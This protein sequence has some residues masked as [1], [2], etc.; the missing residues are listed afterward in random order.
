MLALPFSIL[1]GRSTTRRQASPTEGP[2]SA[3]SA[4]AR[5]RS[6]TSSSARRP[7]TRSVATARPRGHRLPE[8]VGGDA[9]AVRRLGDPRRLHRRQRSARASA[10]ARRLARTAVPGA[11]RAGAA[12]AIRRSGTAARR[13]TTGPATSGRTA[14]TRTGRSASTRASQASRGEQEGNCHFAGEHTSIDFQ[15]YLNGAV[16]TG[17]RAAGEVIADLG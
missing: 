3:S 11:D 9:R 17:E 1:R 15:G 16:E 2:R 10:A 8:H 4:W 5:T 14:P 12:R 6:S 13:S 7:G